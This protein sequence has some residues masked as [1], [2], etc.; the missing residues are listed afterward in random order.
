[1]TMPS[2]NVSSVN[3]IYQSDVIQARVVGQNV[4]EKV[5]QRFRNNIHEANRIAKFKFEKAVIRHLE[6]GVG[7][8]YHPDY[9]SR[10]NRDPRADGGPYSATGPVDFKYSGR[11]HREL[12]GRGRAKP[13]QLTLQVWVSLK[14]RN[15]P[16][17]QSGP[18]TART[19][20]SLVNRL[21]A[22]K[23]PAGVN[24]FNPGK[25]EQQRVANE[26]AAEILG[27]T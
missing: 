4:V 25:A 20:G 1:V 22:Q 5:R 2:A 26:T 3:T 6:G 15:K 19:Y 14:N 21:K 10:K 8:G 18:G 23:S 17:P 27:K 24:P 9:A 13:S 7:G 11:L 16:R 12:K